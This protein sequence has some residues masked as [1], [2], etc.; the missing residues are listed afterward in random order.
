MVPARLALAGVER[1]HVWPGQGEAARAQSD[2]QEAELSERGSCQGAAEKA[3]AANLFI[4][5]SQNG[6]GWKR[7]LRVI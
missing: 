7:P 5:E 2:A 1:S 6:W 3:A 4:L